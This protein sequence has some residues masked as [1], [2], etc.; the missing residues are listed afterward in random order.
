MLVDRLVR[1]YGLRDLLLLFLFLTLIVP[2]TDAA[3]D[4]KPKIAS[5][6]AP[7][8][9]K[10]PHDSNQSLLRE[11][12]S[13][14]FEESQWLRKRKEVTVPALKE[15]LL[16]ATENF[17]D[18][19]FVDLL[20]QNDNDDNDND[21]NVNVP[22]IGIAISG[23]GYRSMLTGAG[24]L[25]AMDDRT[26]NSTI[27]GLGGLL[28]S[29]SYIAGVSGGNWLVGSLAWNNW[30]SVQSIIDNW[31]IDDK[32]DDVEDNT[33]SIGV[34]ET[35]DVTI[36]E[37]AD[38]EVNPIW[39][40][41]DSIIS[42]GGMNIF[43]SAKR[44][45]HISNAIQAKQDAGFETS[46]TDVW[47][48]ALS[49]NF[50]PNLNRGGIDYT[51]SSLRN[52][53]VF[54]DA[55]MPFPISLSDG[56]YPG[57]SV[58]N[59]NATLFEFNPFE[60][61]SWDSSLNAFFDVRYLGSNVSNGIPIKPYVKTHSLTTS[62]NKDNTDVVEDDI[63]DGKE[64][65]IGYDN[66]AFIMATSSTLFNQFL[67]RINSTKLPVP[68]FITR[69]ATHFL[70]DLSQD[71]NDIAVYHP[72]PF[73]DSKFVLDNFTTSITTSDSLYLVDGGEDDENIPFVPL[74]Q[75]DRD[76]D[77]IFAL[78]S[79]AD[80]KLQWPD[81]SSLVHTYERQ[82][83]KQ[84]DGMAFPYVPDTN[85]FTNLGLNKR[86]TFFGCDAS[87]MTDLEYIPPLIVYMPNSE[88]SFQSNQSAFKLSYSETQR[89][90]M[91]QNGFE[92]ATRNN[93][94]D[95][96]DFL[97]CIGCA[98]MRRKQESLNITL[99]IECESC[100]VTYCWDGELDTTELPDSEKDWHHSFV[101][102]NGKPND[103]NSTAKG[104]GTFSSFRYGDSPYLRDSN[105]KDIKDH[106]DEDQYKN[107][108]I[109]TGT[110]I[111][112]KFIMLLLCIM[113]FLVGLI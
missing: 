102:E 83:F 17:E 109:F 106:S 63:E 111:N 81:G 59:L 58:I 36:E 97:S 8:R 28:Q 80:M 16:R 14:S 3:K 29:T 39:D 18:N 70:N 76:L 40:L 86:P 13:I 43:K 22:K 66:T 27:N 87:N 46:L 91:I 49:Y 21:D 32:D 73:K 110:L 53:K 20:F 98:I 55:Q 89:R 15:F 45:D 48:R 100:F 57:S 74:I 19:S 65:I 10:C 85:T 12:N 113:T 30:T 92:I 2:I 62:T 79:S 4:K 6:Y 31:N 96:P 68:K 69:L 104:S 105:S 52:S 61:G 44:W 107:T 56:R 33:D 25:A 67:L 5:N 11:A 84:G 64:C 101:Y 47:G 78:D 50:F 88:Y 35:E 34:S 9:I 82:F 71:Y 26:I 94:T 95:D 7:K 41:H 37:D 108:K 51:W 72:N 1:P 23:G 99:P 77:I 24:V 103:T 54:G 60:M 38:Y 93:F 42:P 112:I 75:K 90:Q